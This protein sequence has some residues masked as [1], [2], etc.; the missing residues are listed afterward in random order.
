MGYGIGERFQV[1]VGSGQLERLFALAPLQGGI[2]DAQMLRE[3][4]AAAR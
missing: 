3:V 1:A 2:V 4:L